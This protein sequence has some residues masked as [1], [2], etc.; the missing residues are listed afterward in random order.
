MVTSRRMEWSGHVA[1]MGEM[2][3][4]Y[5]LGLEILEGRDHSEDLD[6]DVR[7]TLTWEIESEGVH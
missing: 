5:K 1:R 2:R 4:E 3:N 7:K 6:V